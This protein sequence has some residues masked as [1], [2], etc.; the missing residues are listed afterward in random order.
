MTA[1]RS[2]LM[3]V[4]T[5][6]LAAATQVADFEAA[7]AKARETKAPVAVFIHGSDWNRPGE[8][9]LKV[10]N[11]PRLAESAGAATLLVAI[12]RKENPTD[13][14]KATT[15]RNAKCAPPVGSLPAVALY[16]CEGRLVG[17]R[18]GTPEIDAAGGLPATVRLLLAILHKRDDAW[19][20]AASATGPQKAV[21]LAAG[22]NAMGQGLGPGNIYQNILDQIKVADPK[23]E[24]GCASACSFNPWSLLGMVF[25]KVRGNEHAAAEEE[26]AKWGRNSRLGARQRQELHAAR[27]ALYQRWPEKKAMA[28]R[29]LEDMLAVDPK[30]DLGIAARSYLGQLKDS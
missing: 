1:M 4:L 28:K 27:F 11:D 12:D 16:D 5:P 15:Q 30:S 10:W 7:L 29:A 26:L 21:L 6:L 24:S 8:E 19:A 23:D 3:L 25:D 2:I 22:L 17:V 18:S 14:D 9:L 20:R 13:A